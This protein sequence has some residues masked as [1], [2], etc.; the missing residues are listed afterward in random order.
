MIKK[1]TLTKRLAACLMAATMITGA[2]VMS[3]SASAATSTS[4]SYGYSQNLGDSGHSYS[5]GFSENIGQTIN[6]RIGASQT[7][8]GGYSQTNAGSGWSGSGTTKTSGITKLEYNSS[9]IRVK[10]NGNK[11]TV[12]GLKTGTT[13]LKVVY[14]D[15]GTASY[16]INVQRTTRT[17]RWANMA[18]GGIITNQKDKSLYVGDKAIIIL[19][20]DDGL[21]S[22]A[23]TKIKSVTSYNQ[24]V[25]STVNTRRTD[26]KHVIDAVGAGKTTVKVTYAN[27]RVHK[28]TVEVKNP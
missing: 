20:S 21:G 3:I 26:Y 9:K 16:T 5:Q 13:T 18:K 6:I 28:F 12:T 23:T 1:T 10:R 22:G 25:V 4:T 24:K 17:F 14:G 11:I 27:G 8:S 7:F 15:V 2:G 19:G